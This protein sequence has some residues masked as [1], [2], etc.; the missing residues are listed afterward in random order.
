VIK[1]VSNSRCSILKLIPK[2]A[3]LPINIHALT[4]TLFHLLIFRV[5]L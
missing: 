4:L 3:D 5:N 1:C 2:G